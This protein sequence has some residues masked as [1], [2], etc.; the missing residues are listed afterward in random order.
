M[1]FLKVF[2][3][4]TAIVQRNLVF[5]Y[6]NH[7]NKSNTYS[8]KLKTLIKERINLLKQYPDIGKKTEFKAIRIIYL[9]HYSILY[10]VDKEII[11]IVGFWDNRQNPLKLL[12]L[13]REN[14]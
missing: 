10:K 14:K 1:V 3:T 2:W 7:R 5:K 12:R 8:I 6:W 9:E 11:F 13:L 4:E